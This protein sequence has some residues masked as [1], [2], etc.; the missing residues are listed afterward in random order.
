[1]PI[2]LFTSLKL[3]YLKDGKYLNTSW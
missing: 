2:S 3:L 1:M